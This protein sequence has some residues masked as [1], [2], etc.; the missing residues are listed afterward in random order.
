MCKSTGE[1][2]NHLLLHCPTA[3]ELWNLIFTLFGI[4]WVMPRG[5]DD[6]LFC[7]SGSLGNSEFGA[8]WKAIPHCPMWCL[9]HEQNT[10]TFSGVEQSVPALKHSFLQTLY[11]WLNTSNLISSYSLSEMFD[12]CSFEV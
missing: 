6:V 10:R 5:V 2:V 9:W 1:S 12:I 8:I 4:S 7:W 3:Q 11:D